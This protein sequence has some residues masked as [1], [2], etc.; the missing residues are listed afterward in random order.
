MSALVAVVIVI[1]RAMNMGE[2]EAER[3]YFKDLVDRGMNIIGDDDEKEDEWE[4]DD[5]EKQEI[6]DKDI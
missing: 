1:V 2:R 5:E 3:E 6:T 4:D